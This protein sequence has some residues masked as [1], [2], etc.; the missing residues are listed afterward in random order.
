MS[1]FLSPTTS[2]GGRSNV[3]KRTEL[4]FHRLCLPRPMRMRAWNLGRQLYTRESPHF[5][6]PEKCMSPMTNCRNGLGLTSRREAAHFLILWRILTS[7]RMPDQASIEKCVYQRLEPSH[8][9]SRQRM[10]W[11]A[12][13][14]YLALPLFQNPFGIGSIN[15]SV[16]AVTL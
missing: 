14:K 12:W 7:P 16:R 4:F 13:S 9:C 5:Y 10:F 3:L 1:G 15:G 8:F 2:S 11:Y 6:S